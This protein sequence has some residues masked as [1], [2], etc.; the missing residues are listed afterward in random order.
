MEQQTAAYCCCTSGSVTKPSGEGTLLGCMAVVAG[1]ATNQEVPDRSF[2]QPRVYVPVVPGHGSQLPACPDRSHRRDND[3][4]SVRPIHSRRRW[5][6][7]EGRRVYWLPRSRN[8][9]PR[10]LGAQ[11]R[12]IIAVVPRMRSV[13]ARLSIV[14]FSE[15]VCT[16]RAFACQKLHMACA[17]AHQAQLGSSEEAGPLRASQA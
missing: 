15:H 2:E 17:L 14:L 13:P 11:V 16:L 8:G 10:Q 6:V 9:R 12:S 1:C 7:G 4:R 3:V 5:G